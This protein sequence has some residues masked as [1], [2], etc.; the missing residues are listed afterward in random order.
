MTRHCT[1][2]R[3]LLSALLFGLLTVG[4]ARA[5]MDVG[6]EREYQRLLDIEQRVLEFS[7]NRES[8]DIRAQILMLQQR[9]DELAAQSAPVTEVER[10]RLQEHIDQ[11]YQRLEFLGKVIVDFREQLALDEGERFFPNVEH[12]IAVFTFDDPHHT[13]LGDPVSFLLSKKLLFSTRVSSFAIVNYQGGVERAAS[14]ELAY[15]DKVDALSRDQHFLL[16]VWGRLSQTAHDGVRI[17]SFLQVPATADEPPYVQT[18]RLPEAMG[19]GVLTA[20]LKPDRIGIQSLELS[21]DEAQAL[22]AV[23]DEV[24]TLRDA[25][26]I[27]ATKTGQLGEGGTYTD[28]AGYRIVESSGEWVRVQFGD[29][30]GGW[31][32]VDAFC[33]GICSRLMDVAAFTNDVVALTSDQLLRDVPEGVSLEADA[34]AHQLAALV[35]LETSPPRALD[36]FQSWAPS[37]SVGPAPGDTG[38]ANLWAVASIAAELDLD[39][40]DF[41]EIALDRD[42]IAQIADELAIASVADPA[43]LDLLDNL[44]V[45]FGYL[46]DERRRSL[47]GEIAN[48]LRAR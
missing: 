48:S 19:A 27:S 46:G 10:Q 5:G 24:A 26:N 2:N 6:L 32:S 17:D 42:M 16:A 28:N 21:N 9:V 33:T 12:R 1:F 13:G 36:I 31:T 45:L 37:V 11:L 38:F 39:Q 43:D 15:F 29:G 44:S 4:V 34:V 22:R 40:R 7:A 30:S 14:G 35:A 20:R 25:P 23:A 18:L 41:E 3:A 47:A 8:E